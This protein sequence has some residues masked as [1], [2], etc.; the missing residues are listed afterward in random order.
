MTF[1]RWLGGFLT[2]F[3]VLAGF[4]VDAWVLL[5]YYGDGPPYYGRT[6]NMDKWSSP[7]WILVVVSVCALI[8]G[9][10]GA[11]LWSRC[12][13]QPSNDLRSKEISDSS[14]K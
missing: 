9:A 4:A 14:L 11:R 8:V 6:T 13:F 12:R 7:F 3:W 10:W 2:A 1:I 5:E